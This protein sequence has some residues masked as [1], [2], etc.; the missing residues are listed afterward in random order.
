MARVVRYDIILCIFGELWVRCSEPRAYLTRLLLSFLGPI[1][2]ERGVY[3]FGSVIAFVPEKS[4]RV[5]SSEMFIIEFS[6]WARMH[7]FDCFMSRHNVSQPQVHA[8]PVNKL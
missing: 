1:T 7:A 2:Y 5:M 4:S 8:F 6:L 3:F